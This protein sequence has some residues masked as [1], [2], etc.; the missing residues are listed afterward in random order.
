[1]K[2][3][4]I[5]N[6]RVPT[7]RAQGYA[8]VKMCEQFGLLGAT[9][10]LFVPNRRDVDN[11]GEPFSYYK[12]SKIFELITINNPDFLSRTLRLSRFV[13][14]IDM[15]LF[16][17]SVNRMF[18]SK[19]EDFYYTRDFFIALALPAKANICLEIHDMPNGK[20][21]FVRA[22]NKARMIVVL[23]DNLKKSLIEMGVNAEK[24][25][26]FPSGV[27][28]SEFDIDLSKSEA[29]GLVKLPQDK[30]IVLY[31]GH[32]YPWK[33]AEI[34]AETAKSMNETMF[35]FVGGV[36]PELSFFKNKYE[37]Y[38]NIVIRP[39]EPRSNI[40]L[41]LKSADVLVIPSPSKY[42]ISSEYTSPIKM[43]EYMASGRPIVA[44]DLPSLTEILNDNNCVLTKPDDAYSLG[45]SIARVLQDESLSERISSQASM[46][47]LKYSWSN[48]AKSI[49]TLIENTVQNIHE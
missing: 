1:M 20:G 28:V 43:F 5:T 14:W 13:Y 40:P 46:D 3:N 12:V 24:I 10:S 45:K 48:R 4:Y 6:V 26:I 29:R 27:E 15:I 7:T 17:I 25:F 35:V 19:T 47:V 37:S 16:L 38:K 31:S 23:N 42:K 30:K 44:S 33:G 11:L 39:F 36:E 22:L 32:L 34:L 41:Y 8:I 21:S 2:I 49:L 9:V 18:K